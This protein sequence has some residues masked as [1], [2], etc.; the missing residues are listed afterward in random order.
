MIDFQGECEYL[1]KAK[2]VTEVQDPTYD[3]ETNYVEEIQQVK[4]EK[5]DAKFT[6]MKQYV[7]A[8]GVGEDEE[9]VIKEYDFDWI[10]LNYS[11]YLFAYLYYNTYLYLVFFKCVPFI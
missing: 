7:K 9:K 6:A 11:L 2:D 5:N 1:N 3:E 4:K 8:E 10:Q